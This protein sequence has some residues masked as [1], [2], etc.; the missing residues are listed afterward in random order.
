[1][2]TIPGGQPAGSSY[3]QEPID[4]GGV[5]GGEDD[6]LDIVIVDD[7]AGPDR[8]WSPEGSDQPLRG[9]NEAAAGSV[10]EDADGRDYD[11]E[12]FQEQL[13]AERRRREDVE[14]K[15]LEQQEQSERALFESERRNLAIQRDSFKLAMDGIDVRIRTTTEALK[16]ARTDGD[17]GAETD[18]EMQLQELRSIKGQIE[19]NMHKLPD[20]R[21]MQAD[22]DRYQ[23]DRRKQVEAQ[24]AA[25]SSQDAPKALNKKA[26]AWQKQ[27]R[28]MADPSRTNERTALMEVNNA[29]V[30][31][32]YD[33]NTDDFFHEMSRRMAKRFPGL[34]VRD[35]AG[36][37]VGQQARPA[38]SQQQRT[39]PPVAG[40]RSS[41][42]PST[43]VK[44]N[45]LQLD[46]GDVR[47]MRAL[48]IDM[49][50]E[51]AKKYYAKEKFARLRREQQL[52]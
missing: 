3:E 21:Q 27:N 28:W 48:G 31:E 44:R 47:I 49:N 13:S 33:A 23:A 29:L 46:A 12:R 41:A 39:A 5:F 7:E 9:Q 25:A 1:M 51:A 34:A 52:R 8:E 38:Q 14:R 6:E 37:G 35:L 50:D 18:L 15:H 32:G 22:F 11:D 42:P 24:R 10:A 40:A 17:A 30:N 16:Y 2:S 43:Q 19:Q 4:V 20:E 36:A 26:E 45:R